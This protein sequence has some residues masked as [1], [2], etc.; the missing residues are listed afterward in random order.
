[1]HTL[2]GVRWA[3][4]VPEL[5]RPRAADQAANQRIESATSWAVGPEWCGQE[6]AGREQLLGAQLP[7][8]N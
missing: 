5:L 6:E 7:P 8:P 3:N 1:M 4:V 2:A